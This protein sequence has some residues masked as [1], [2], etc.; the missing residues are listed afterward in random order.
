MKTTLPSTRLQELSLEMFAKSLD[1]ISYEQ[2]RK[3]KDVF[4][5]ELL[6]A[7]KVVTIEKI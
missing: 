3:V 6:L 4:L 2:K 5:A 7:N 1:C